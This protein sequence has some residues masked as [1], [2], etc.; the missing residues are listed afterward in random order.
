MTPAARLVVAVRYA[1]RA[2]ELLAESEK[3]PAGDSMARELAQRAAVWSSCAVAQ[4]VIAQA[5]VTIPKAV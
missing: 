5:Q 1:D 2:L 4:A 3:A